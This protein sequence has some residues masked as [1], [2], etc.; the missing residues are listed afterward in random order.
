MLREGE[1]RVKFMPKTNCLVI[2]AKRAF[3]I[4]SPFLCGGY[5]KMYNVPLWKRKVRKIY[6]KKG[7][8]SPLLKFVH[9][10]ENFSEF[11]I[12]LSKIIYFSFGTN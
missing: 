8:F 2:I 6:L 10:S 11:V 3:H 5:L 7:K 4:F 12:Y 9:F 1:S